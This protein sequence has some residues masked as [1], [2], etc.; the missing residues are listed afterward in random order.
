[1]TQSP[2]PHPAPPESPG[3][4]QPPVAADDETALL[5]EYL[6]STDAACPACGYNLRALTTPRC[7]ECG[8]AIRLSVA[9]VTPHMRA[10][11]AMTATTAMTAG[12]GLLF[13]LI[14]ESARFAAPPAS[15]ARAYFFAA[16]PIVVV[17]VIARRP[18]TRLPAPLQRSIATVLAALSLSALLTA[19]VML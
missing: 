19:I 10:W 14:N 17:L 18:I 8:L 9:P 15:L 16:I 2:P 7:P 1:M 13:T 4:P 5:L 12:I 3:G 6:Q 11:L